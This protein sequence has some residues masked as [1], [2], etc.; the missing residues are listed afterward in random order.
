MCKLEISTSRFEKESLVTFEKLFY[1]YKNAKDSNVDEPGKEKIVN[2]LTHLP[3]DPFSTKLMELFDYYYLILSEDIE[4]II[5]RALEM[6]VY[7]EHTERYVTLEEKYFPKWLQPFDTQLKSLR[8]IDH[9]GDLCYLQVYKVRINFCKLFKSLLPFRKKV[10]RND[11][12][13]FREKTIQKKN[14]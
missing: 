14:Y 5:R 10:S 2:K 13:V 12:I 3:N 1:S 7:M 6:R 8:V 4:S 9:E 11:L